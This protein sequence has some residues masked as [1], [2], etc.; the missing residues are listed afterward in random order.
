MRIKKRIWCA[1]KWVSHCFNYI[2]LIWEL[3][4][5]WYI[6]EH[7]WYIIELSMNYF[8]EYS[9]NFYWKIHMFTVHMNQWTI[10]YIHWKFNEH[11]INFWKCKKWMFTN[12]I[13][14][15]FCSKLNFQFDPQPFTTIQAPPRAEIPKRDIIQCQFLITNTHPITK[16]HQMSTKAVSFYVNIFS[17]SLFH[18]EHFSYLY[19]SYTIIPFNQKLSYDDRSERSKSIWSM[20]PF[21]PVQNRVV[22]QAV[23]NHL[24]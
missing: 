9:M 8:T 2:H 3:K 11:I 23:L 17:Y 4:V 19:H 22:S 6:S 21:R 5:Q 13:W 14:Y 12:T 7:L 16:I 24:W 10:I 20:D 15:S 18:L 1:T